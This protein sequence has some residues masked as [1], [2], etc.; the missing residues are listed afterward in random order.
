[1]LL[2]EGGTKYCFFFSG[3]ALLGPLL[4]PWEKRTTSSL[5]DRGCVDSLYRVR[6]VFRGQAGKV[7]QMVCPPPQW[8]HIQQTLYSTLLLF[9]VP[10][11]WSRF[12]KMAVFFLDLFLKFLSRICPNCPSMQLF[13]WRSWVLLWKKLPIF[14]TVKEN[15]HYALLKEG[16]NKASNSAPSVQNAT[17]FLPSALHLSQPR[18]PQFDPYQFNSYKLQNKSLIS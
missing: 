16:K 15:P 2:M 9:P 5:V 18:P 11:Y 7:V 10:C 13:L 4:Q 6:S 14:C 8:C 3:K 1:M 17:L 12:L